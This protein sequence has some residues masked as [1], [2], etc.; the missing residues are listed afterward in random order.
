MS[1]IQCL[2]SSLKRLKTS[3]LVVAYLFQEI[4]AKYRLMLSMKDDIYA[5]NS[6]IVRFSVPPNFYFRL[7]FELIIGIDFLSP[8][9]KNMFIFA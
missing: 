9:L 4:F 6:Y 7:K 3:F 8:G 5:E 1:S 2:C